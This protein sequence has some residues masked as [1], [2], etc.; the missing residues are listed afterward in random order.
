M[1]MPVRE[2]IAADMRELLADPDIN[3]KLAATGQVVNPGTPAEFAAA[4][5]DQTEK[6]KEIGKT[7]GIKLGQ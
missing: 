6:V 4:L 7:L 3:A 5:A 2:R 1:P